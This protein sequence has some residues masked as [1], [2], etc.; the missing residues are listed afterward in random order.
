MSMRHWINLVEARQTRNSTGKSVQPTD[1]E[2]EKAKL[3][4]EDAA[5]AAELARRTEYY[6]PFKELQRAADAED[7]YPA[8][9]ALTDAEGNAAETEG[10][11]YDSAEYWQAALNSICETE[12]FNSDPKVRQWF[13]DHGYR[14]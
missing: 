5:H 3:D 14:W 1:W 6:R 9:A 4:A 12:P 10:V 2:I 8:V 11:E 13:E 7:F